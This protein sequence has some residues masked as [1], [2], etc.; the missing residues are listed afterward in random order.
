MGNS[1]SIMRNKK[2]TF[3]KNV[4]TSIRTLPL[5]LYYPF[6]PLELNYPSRSLANLPRYL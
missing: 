5:S 3:Y 2:Q 4:E 1:R 6:A